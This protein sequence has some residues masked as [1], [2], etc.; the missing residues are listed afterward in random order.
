M[1]KK[2]QPKFLPPEEL[3]EGSAEK[4]ISFRKAEAS[5]TA[6]VF[7]MFSKPFLFSSFFAF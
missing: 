4:V 7:E 1:A 2:L 5:Y 6:H 3:G